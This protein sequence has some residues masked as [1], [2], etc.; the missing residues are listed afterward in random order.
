MR[1]NSKDYLSFASLSC[2]LLI[3]LW[4]GL[5]S[6]DKIQ[7]GL[8]GIVAI[9]VLFGLPYIAFKT[10]RCKHEDTSKCIFDAPYNYSITFSVTFVIVVIAMLVTNT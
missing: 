1:D 6:S 8:R 2:V 3:P 4:I 10:T 7:G 9:S 5:A